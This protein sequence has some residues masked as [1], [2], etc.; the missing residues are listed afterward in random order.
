MDKNKIR[1][2][3]AEVL[4]AYKINTTTIITEYPT[5]NEAQ[6]IADLDKE[7]AD[8]KEELETYLK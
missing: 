7:I 4:Q 1:E 8:Y 5:N 3:F 6:A 2:L